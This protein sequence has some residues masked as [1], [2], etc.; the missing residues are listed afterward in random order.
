MGESTGN[1][2]RRNCHELHDPI[3]HLAYLGLVP[4]EIDQ[5]R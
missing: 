3:D 4:S 5:Q 2:N 1:Q